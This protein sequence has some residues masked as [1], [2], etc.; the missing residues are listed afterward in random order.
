MS[1]VNMFLPINT[2]FYDPFSSTYISS[3]NY[4]RVFVLFIAKLEPIEE[5]SN[6]NSFSVCILLHGCCIPV[7]LPNV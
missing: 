2:F 6:Y 7:C 4:E 3:F 1:G 5:L